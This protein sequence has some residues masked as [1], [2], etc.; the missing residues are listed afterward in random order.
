MN[1]AMQTHIG[2]SCATKDK[3]YKSGDDYIQGVGS[4]HMYTKQG[5]HKHLICCCGWL[6]MVTDNVVND[7]MKNDKFLDV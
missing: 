5:K 3:R 1:Q 4:H 7:A 2:I 6:V